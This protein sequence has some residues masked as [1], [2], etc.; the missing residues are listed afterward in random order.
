MFLLRFDMR[1]PQP[2][3]STA[4]LYAAALE[5]C[6]WSEARGALGVLFCQH[7]TSPDGYLPSPMIMGT[8]AAARTTTLPIML[9]AVLLPFYDPVKLAEDMNV[10]DIISKGRVS[11]TFGLGYRP[12]EYEHF[13]VDRS[14]RGR[15]AE[16]KLDLLVRLR[17]GE[18][19]EVDGRR[20]HV[21]PPS[22][23]PGGPVIRWGGS[24]IAAAQR[25]GRHGLALQPN[26]G[27]PGLREAYEEASRAHG[28][29][30]QP[31]YIPEKDTAAVVFVADD[32]DAAWAEIGPYLFH[33]ST[34]YSSWNEGDSTSAMISHASSIDDL[35]ENWP[36]YQIWSVDEAAEQVAA[37]RP[38]SL[39]PLC[40]GIPPEVAWP[41]L[42][43]AATVAAAVPT[44]G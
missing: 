43:R 4:E 3:A 38:L 24:S 29:E 8:A 28:H 13:G 39:V 7:H 33:D 26:G 23:T 21:T 40:G 20:I 32:V 25:A 17:T 36:G 41:Y 34:T 9:G 42:E 2:G 27:V 6:T 16:E 19:V 31:L 15:I 1:A 10:L 18:P 12:E 30:P 11:Y 35:R 14:R 22:Y 37:G 5:M 44:P